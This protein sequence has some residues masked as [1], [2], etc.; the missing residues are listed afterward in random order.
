MDLRDELFAL[1]DATAQSYAHAEGMKTRWAD[2]EKAQTNLYQVSP[3]S[4]SF[5]RIERPILEQRGGGAKSGEAALIYSEIVLR[6]CICDSATLSPHRT[7]PQ[8]R[9]LVRS[10]KEDQLDRPVVGMEERAD[11]LLALIHPLR[12]KNR[13][14]AA[15][16]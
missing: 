14:P 2:I 10:S 4:N 12:V 5:N 7:I 15:I 9:L 1:R 11:M 3:L 6:F 8:K 16:G 13:L